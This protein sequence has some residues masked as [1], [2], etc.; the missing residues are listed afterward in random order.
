VTRDD[1]LAVVAELAESVDARIDAEAIRDD[2]T[3]LTAHGLTSLAALQLYA[4]LED[5]FGIT[6]SDG[7]ALRAGTGASLVD[8]VREKAAPAQ[9]GAS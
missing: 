7:E 9:S 4:K 3:P 8:L 5:R 6:I 1:I 2:D